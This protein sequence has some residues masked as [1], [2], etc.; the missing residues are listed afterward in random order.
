MSQGE[1]VLHMMRV[2]EMPVSDLMEAK[3]YTLYFL[4][5]P[6]GGQRFHYT[7]ER[8]HYMDEDELLP[9]GVDIGGEG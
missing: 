1:F 4:S 3:V 2:M 6:F 9:F 5:A 7:L 8:V